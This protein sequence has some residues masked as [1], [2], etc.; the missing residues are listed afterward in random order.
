M[1]AWRIIGLYVVV[2]IFGLVDAVAV[3]SIAARVDL[4]PSLIRVVR[5]RKNIE[6]L[7]HDPARQMKAHVVNNH[8]L[9][10]LRAYYQWIRWVI[11]IDANRVGRRSW[12]NGLTRIAG[13]QLIGHC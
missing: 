9:F 12:G 3:D 5:I 6:P 1:S 10:C 13:F 8:A 4:I 7:D 11:T 2:R